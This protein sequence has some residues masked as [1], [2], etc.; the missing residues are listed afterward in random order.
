MDDAADRAPG[1]A[2]Y[3]AAMAKAQR[4][5]G[6]ALFSEGLSYF[7]YQRLICRDV[8]I[9]WIGRRVPLEGIRVGDFGAHE[10]GMLD[11]L[12]ES[13]LVTTA[14]GLELSAEIVAASP[15]VPDGRFRLEVLDLME[16]DGQYE[17]DLIILHDVLEH[18]PDGVRA[19]RAV[20][21]SLAP[22]GTAFVSF[23]PYYSAFGG[24]QQL[25]RGTARHVPFI[26]FLP[27]RLFFR[28]AAP[29]TQEYMT[30]EASRQDM[31]SVRRTKLT[32]TRAERAFSEAGLKVLD[33]EL[34]V[35]RPEYK[36]RYGL[37]TRGASV[38][39]R[40]PGLR[41]LVV[42]GAFFLV[43]RHRAERF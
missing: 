31:I 11:A 7:E 33:S 24:H 39:G 41:E 17:F 3:C 34:F 21:D 38:L 25:A 5:P 6:P 12:R 27:R 10:G 13:G 37:E 42:N 9:P 36:L 14:V 19:L 15:F 23:P 43:Q 35:V 26:H 18:I 29:G 16:T 32:L 20:H 40:V 8:L 30:A 1:G 4:W 28:C 2:S 22:G